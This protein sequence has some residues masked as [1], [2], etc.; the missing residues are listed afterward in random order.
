MSIYSTISTNALN[1]S[2]QIEP[3]KIDI[4]APYSEWGTAAGKK[5]APPVSTKSMDDEAE[6]LFS[7]DEERSKH[8]PKPFGDDDPK[9]S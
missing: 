1:K 7:D 3:Q 6:E 8:K 4:N 9:K 5:I 2:T